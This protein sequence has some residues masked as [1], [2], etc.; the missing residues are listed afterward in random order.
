MAIPLTYP[1]LRGLPVRVTGQKG[2]SRIAPNAETVVLQT[3]PACAQAPAPVLGRNRE[4]AAFDK[5]QPDE[6]C[7]SALFRR[8]AQIRSDWILD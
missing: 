6:E 4:T 1:T 7:E 2:Y 5:E 3:H 8:R